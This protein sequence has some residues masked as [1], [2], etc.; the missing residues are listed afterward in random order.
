MPSDRSAVSAALP[1]LGRARLRQQIADS[2][3]I[4]PRQRERSSVSTPSSSSSDSSS[5]DAVD[6]SA[7]ASS[8]A[9]GPLRNAQPVAKLVGVAVLRASPK[10]ANT[11]GFFCN[12]DCK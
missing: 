7:A 4:A 3:Q 2:R 12:T 10:A 8:D 1:F 11:T 9:R 6:A 5:S